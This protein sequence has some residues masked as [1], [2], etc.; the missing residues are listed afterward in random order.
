MVSSADTYTDINNPHPHRSMPDNAPA[1][2]L[3]NTN[4]QVIDH[5]AP[6]DCAILRIYCHMARTRLLLYQFHFIHITNQDHI[7]PVMNLTRQ[8]RRAQSI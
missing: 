5:T 1:P 7:H 6:T 4:H 3:K 8:T 2:T